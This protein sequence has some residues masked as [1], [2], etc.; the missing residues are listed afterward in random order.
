MDMIIRNISLVATPEGKKAV[1]G[2]KMKTLHCRKDTSII[3]EN[4]KIAFLGPEKEAFRYCKDQ[5]KTADDYKIL[6]GKGKCALPGFIDSHT[7]FIFGGYRPE[8]FMMRLAG[9]EYLE[10]HRMGGGIEATVQA[11]RSASEEE[12]FYQVDHI[13]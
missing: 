10:I 6:E 5:N 7:H 4:G 9:K 12:L 2:E 8:E 1:H 11:T 13:I 3:I